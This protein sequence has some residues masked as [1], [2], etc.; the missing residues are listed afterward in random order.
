MNRHQTKALISLVAAG[1]VGCYLLM[2]KAT[3]TSPIDL[4]KQ[5]EDLTSCQ[6]NLNNLKTGIEMWASDNKNAYPASLS[7][8]TPSYLRSVPTC[9]AAKSDTYSASY[10]VSADG[11]TWSVYCAGKAH[12]GVDGCLENFP[13]CRSGVGVVLH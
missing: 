9:P 1:F 13:A 8:L 11:K 4:R 2:A 12:A 7:P 10:Q 6:A 5:R 3:G